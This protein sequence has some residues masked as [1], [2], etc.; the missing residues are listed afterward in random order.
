MQTDP[1]GARAVWREQPAMLRKMSV[2]GTTP[3]ILQFSHTS[4]SQL[5][6]D[7]EQRLGRKNS[8]SNGF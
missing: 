4:P 1:A 6:E 8:G 2:V 3:E 5:A 7:S